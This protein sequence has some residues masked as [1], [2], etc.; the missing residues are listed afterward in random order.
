M[1]GLMPW[2]FEQEIESGG[3]FI[4]HKTPDSSKLLFRWAEEPDPL[5]YISMQRMEELREIQER[6]EESSTLEILMEIMS[7]YNKGADF[8]TIVTE[9]N[10]VR[11][12]RRNLVASILTGYHCF[13]QRA[14]SPVWH[15]DAKK[16]VQGADKSKR[17]Y[18][19][20]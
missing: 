13:Y 15:Y 18:A 12:V 5:C 2:Y 17:K 8:I 6:S 19:K 7:H 4:L 10:V 11:R 20:K 3:V 9:L 16:V 1:F 14:G